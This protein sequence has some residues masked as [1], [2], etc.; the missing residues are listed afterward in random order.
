M[1][2]RTPYKWAIYHF[3]P[4]NNEHLEALKPASD[5]TVRVLPN[6]TRVKTLGYGALQSTGRFWGAAAIW[7]AGNRN[8][9]LPTFNIRVVLLGWQSIELIRPRVYLEQKRF[10][11]VGRLSFS[12]LLHFTPSI[13]ATVESMRN[14]C[15]ASVLAILLILF[16]T[17]GNTLSPSSTGLLRR[18]FH[19][20]ATISTISS[21]GDGHIKAGW[22]RRA[23][24][25]GTSGEYELSLALGDQLMPIQ[26]AAAVI[27]SFYQGV[28]GKTINYSLT[29]R[30]GTR[31][32]IFRKGALVLFFRCLE[33]GRS[34]CL[35]WP[36]MT[37]FAQYMMQRAQTGFTG[38]YIGHVS[39]P[40]GV[41]ASVTFAIAGTIARE[42]MDSA[43][44]IH[45][46]GWCYKPQR[47]SQPQNDII[48]PQQSQNLLDSVRRWGNGLLADPWKRGRKASHGNEQMNTDMKTTLDYHVSAYLTLSHAL[49]S[50]VQISWRH[51]K[52][53]TFVE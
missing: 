25:T 36:L 44:D 27:E 13:R 19:Q 5:L 43:S 8:I 32:F 7:L 20:G 6:I 48:C 17:T 1:L 31:S 49:A 46:P 41:L 22:R 2:Q 47:W 30:R 34:G 37:M 10:H 28:M 14:A 45:G 15:S 50:W 35:P 21:N 39:G 23:L 4:Y 40:N 9:S 11:T 52:L 3:S 42:L 33:G 29:N 12:H 24:L 38:E 18:T 53:S 51:V 26:I 16:C